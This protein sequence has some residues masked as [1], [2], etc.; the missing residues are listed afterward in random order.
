MAGKLHESPSCNLLHT[1][2]CTPRVHARTHWHQP[3]CFYP[4]FL[5]TSLLSSIP[6]LPSFLYYAN[7]ITFS[8]TLQ[9]TCKA[10]DER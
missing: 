6:I 1:I 4:L 5:F 2:M 8:S 7:M 9:C 10:D 3:N